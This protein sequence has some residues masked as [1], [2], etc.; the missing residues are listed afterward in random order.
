MSDEKRTN[1]ND[2]SQR[3]KEPEGGPV[4]RNGHFV[5]ARATILQPKREQ[6]HER[7]DEGP[8][9]PDPNRDDRLKPP[10]ADHWLKNMQE[11]RKRQLMT[12]ELLDRVEVKG[13][14]PEPFSPPP[15]VN[16]IPIGPSVAMQGQGAT[17]PAVSGRVSGVTIAP[18]GN[19]VYVATANGGVW[20][21]NDGGDNWSSTMDSL[22]LN[23]T[24][25]AADTL[26]CGAIA[27]DMADPDRVYVGT[28]EGATAFIY[29]L[30]LGRGV[31][32]S[33]FGVGPL[34]S[35]D[36]GVNWHLEPVAAGSPTLAGQ[37]FFQLAV[38][39]N[40]RELVVAATTAG[41]YCRQFN[42]ALNGGA[43]GYEWVQVQTGQWSDVVVARPSG[44][45][46]TFVAVQYGG[47]VFSSNDGTTWTALGT[48]FPSSGTSRIVLAI[49]PDS[50]S[51]VYAIVA[52]D[53]TFG[54][55]QGLYRYDASD[56]TWHSISGSPSVG[57]G[58]A[59]YDF[60]LAVDPNNV[61]TIYMGGSTK[62]ISGQWSGE[63]YHGAVT[64]S[65]TGTGLTYSVTTTGIGGGAHADVQ[66]LAFT[67]TSSTQLW[68]GTDGG[69]F[70]A[71][72]AGSSAS[73]EQRNVGLQTLT[74]N[75]MGLHPTEPAVIFAGSQD[76]G[77]LRFVGEECW[78]HS[79]YGDGGY[80]IINWN[81]PYKVLRT[82]TGISVRRTT[83]GGQ[84][85]TSWMNASPPSSGSL[86]YGPLAGCPQSTT[87][88]DAEIAAAGSSTVWLTTDFGTSW[89]ALPSGNATQ[90]TGDTLPNTCSAITFASASCLY[91]ATVNG[92]VYRYD[93]SGTTWT[94]TQI[95]T[96]GGTNSLPLS[97]WI[98]DIA[99]DLADA[100]GASI[101]ITFGGNGDW[102]HV[103]HW[104]GTQWGARSGSASGASDALLD[105]HH[106]AIIV[107]PA[108]T[109]HVYVG[110][111]IGVWRSTNGGTAW[112]VFSQGLP[113]AAIVD[114]K[115]HAAGRL[116]RATTHGR[117]AWERE[118]DATSKDGV[119]LY[120]RDTWLDLGRYPT[121]NY[122]DD[123]TSPG[124]TV[125]HWKTPNIIV[126]VPSNAGTYQTTS[127]DINFYEFNDVIV[128]GSG[129][130]ATVD[131]T[132]GT[133][134]NRV[135]VEVRNRGVL[136]ANNV[137]VML[138][139][140]D[141]SGGL[142]SLPPGYT[143]NLQA[144][145]NISSADWDTVGQVMLQNLRVGFPQIA[146]FSLPS[147]LLPPPSSL[148]GHTHHCLLALLHSADDPFTNTGTAVDPLSVGDRKSAHKNLHIVHFTGTIPSVS[149]EDAPSVSPAI[150]W[151]AIKL[152]GLPPM[153]SV[154]EL[155][156]RIGGYPGRVDLLL[157]K[158]I[159][160]ADKAMALE[161]WEVH[162]S[163]S[164]EAWAERTMGFLEESL[165]KGR[166]N[167]ART[168]ERIE[169][170]HRAANQPLLT[171]SRKKGDAVLPG[172]IIKEGKSATVFLAI[173]RP[174]N[175][176]IGDS[177]KIGLSQ[178]IP[179]KE[180][181]IEGGSV[182][183]IQVVPPPDH[184][185]PKLPFKRRVITRR[186]RKLLEVVVLGQYGKPLR[187]S[188][189]T[190]VLAVF[191]QKNG[192]TG[193]VE[194][195][196]FNK[197]RFVFELPLADLPQ[198]AQG[199]LR[200][201]LVVRRRELESRETLLLSI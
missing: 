140:A 84:S 22:D 30:I 70:R 23:P 27:I 103:W 51:V 9:D 159:E 67:P 180:E 80:A 98:T 120:N 19:R 129:G 110:A 196:R 45:P 107:D 175:G 96:L 113:D 122:L 82:Y 135:Y 38:D 124:D 170:I 130:V 108:N 173:H 168:K 188:K 43:G 118:I 133:V 134:I 200:L 18:G 186:Q 176:T 47:T 150:Q 75:H 91:A 146:Y 115:I 21:S 156:L 142:P 46:T 90:Q 171:W 123:P 12:L 187:S 165:K 83:D 63:I 144:G 48:G 106:N 164:V 60:S 109:S 17:R 65:G 111:D 127:T 149:G 86:F 32:M 61:N 95:D 160:L 138:L 64:S 139:H 201:T 162:E 94:R 192:A 197:T 44:G 71:N 11:Y 177:W 16:W 190:A 185:D 49:Q 163:R 104:N 42:A 37:A 182:W 189:D 3:G 33:Y 85:A 147:T 39:P 119:E 4:G 41:L 72:N 102:Q 89:V 137:R 87:T 34:R 88:A 57:D 143:A 68:A 56:N 152:H 131:P 10:P 184:L 15:A 35:D 153:E 125:R 81:D 154:S 172:V 148:A 2:I 136:P 178:R 54:G 20:R 100:T 126:D 99:I 8:Y 117:S 155:V 141:A 69:L 193:T 1:D 40:N 93:L 36:G 101:Y 77:T 161:G 74:M 59:R 97:G 25:L 66:Y 105:I 132:T 55:F 78:L 145:T 73:F 14:R 31:N 128:D 158:G 116:I 112:S 5:R 114:L 29:E 28:G 169:Q 181:P 79:A 13:D 151:V 199:E 167:A 76:N 174:K 58:Q 52:T 198:I 157:P 179:S 183:Q 191:Y 53:S 50:V 26:A 121:V 7:N 62:Y 195:L 24:Q 194:P 166:F 92:E 6:N